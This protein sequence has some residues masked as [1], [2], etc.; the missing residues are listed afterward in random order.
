MKRQHRKTI[1]VYYRFIVLLYAVKF[2]V[3]TLSSVLVLFY[4]YEYY[5]LPGVESY[6]N[7]VHS[8]ADFSPV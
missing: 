6:D 7:L 1:Y 3:K 4:Q 5:S 2:E 8:P